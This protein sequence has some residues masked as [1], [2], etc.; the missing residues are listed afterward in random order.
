M[1]RNSM[2]IV[3][4][5]VLAS[6]LEIIDTSIVN[7]ALPSMMGNLG[8]TLEDISM[9]ITGYAIANAVVLPLSAWL[10]ERIGR[11]KY[12]LGCILFFTATSVACGFAPNLFLLTVFRILQGLA[13]GAL[14]PTSQALIYEQ[15]PKEKAGM[16]G[17]IFGMS[18]M[19]GP[20]LGPV[21]GGYLTDEF[22]W[23]SIFNVNLPLG[24][25]AFFVGLAVIRNP[26][27]SKQPE[28]AVRPKLDA[29][30]LGLLV[31]G[32]GCLQY[33]L[34][35][36]E[37]DDWFSSTA[38]IVNT[39]LAVVCLPTFVWWELKVE[40]PIINIRL[41]KQSIVRN[42]TLLMMF[43]GFFL[44]SVVFLL[45]VFVGRVFHY[46]ATQTGALFIP[47]SLLTM[48]L[49][50]M[51]GKLM[52]AGKNPK[53]LILIGFLSIELC[54]YMMTLFSPLTSKPELYMML[55]VRGF[56]L[57][58]LFVPINSS[59]LSQFHGAALGQVS[60]LLNLFRQIGGSVGIALVG[61]LLNSR[62]HQNYLDLTSKVSM[63][64]PNTQA[65]VNQTSQGLSKKMVEDMGRASGHDATLQ[66]LYYKIQNQVFMMS[67]LQLITVIMILFSLAFIPLY[68]L[69]LREKPVLVTD[70][71]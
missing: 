5:A 66:I 65:F 23:R 2:L 62:S 10:G 46:D 54:L 15:F 48:A 28:G 30:G 32:I 16:A 3:F 61:T 50:P 39:I 26:E 37:A 25:L 9:V 8:A 67:F 53:I 44:Y 56:A 11:R 40:N 7:V 24:L 45:P 68:L 43:V 22:G 41:F 64:N 33:V 20:T 55:F 13:G 52:Q 42:G 58:F 59:I 6:L 12:Y 71:H 63:L 17:A 27:H 14:L 70:A 29:V 69:R 34:E 38:I 47:G 51:I 19:I 4:V 60:G 36:G 35:R 21:M 31:A 49:M 57:A 18:V 1:S